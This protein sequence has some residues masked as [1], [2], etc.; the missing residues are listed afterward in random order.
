VGL[1]RTLLERGA[2]PDARTAETFPIRNHVLPIT[3]SLSW[4]DF[5][6]QTPFITAALSGD[7]TVMRML[8]EHGA[9]PHI[10]T[11]EG[12]SALMAAAGVN[13]VVAQTFDEGPEA[14]LEAVRLCLELGLDVNDQNSMG[15]TA[16]MGAANRGSDDIIRFLVDEGA[17]LDIRD[18]EGR[19]AFDW[20]SGVFLAT[21]AAVPKPSSMALIREYM[22]DAGI[23]V[24]ET[25]AGP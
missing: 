6:G 21:H 9:D 25:E 7:L 3:S 10:K 11:L 22:V 14:L 13:W 17:R 12:T 5:I 23:E 4:V 24:A 16:L 8:L 2:D 1:I 19:N 20:A 15:V 18:G